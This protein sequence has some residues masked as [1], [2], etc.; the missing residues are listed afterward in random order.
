MYHRCN[1][2][3]YVA[4]QDVHTELHDIIQLYIGKH[5]YKY[6]C[7]DI[8][9]VYSSLWYIFV[10][11]GIHT[12]CISNDGIIHGKEVNV[13]TWS[14]HGPRNYTIKKNLEYNHKILAYL[15]AIVQQIL[16][17]SSLGIRTR[18]I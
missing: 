13:N 3:W 15:H 11:G 12:F 18:I 1:A 8:Q 7:G 4:L 10:I 6:I 2:E 17:V 16:I 9:V 14:S 5:A